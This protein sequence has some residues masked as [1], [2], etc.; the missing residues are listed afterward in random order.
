MLGQGLT[1]FFAMSGMLI[2]L[3]FVRD[4][5][6]GRRRL[7]VG[8]YAIRR[9]RRVF[10]VY[11][12]IFVVANFALHAVYVENAVAVH[13]PRSDAGTGELTG[14]VP[15]LLNL[16]LLQSFSPQWLQTGINPSWSLTT[17][18]TFYALLPLLMIPLVGRVR[19]RFLA[20]LAPA[21]VLWVGGLCGRAWA[22][23]LF[24]GMVGVS[25]LEA[26]YGPHPVAVLSRSLLGLGDMFA[27]GI[28]IAVL[29]V[30]TER[31]E[32]PQ[33]TARRARVACALLLVAGTA[34]AIFFHHRE[35]WLLGAFTTLVA[36]AL[37][38]RITD[39]EA[40]GDSSRFV[41]MIGWRPLD[42]VGRVSLSVYLVHFPVIVLL[43]RAR[44]FTHDSVLSAVGSTL[45]TAAI[46]LAVAAVTYA[47]I[48][49]PA[50]TGEWP[51]W[52]SAGRQSRP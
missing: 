11:I 44:L 31:G 6:A 10:P 47:W 23:Y 18:L 50:L 49:R 36:G 13:T 41:R 35:P 5:A 25:P 26:E 27:V 20:A 33:W 37:V 14:W 4:I 52:R 7:R 21:A 19:R 34:G 24:H 48:E 16:T 12:A 51:R 38:L 46:S 29:F 40:R 43:T 15:V 32:L 3:P 1:V 22:T 28:V 9:L 2:S 42:Y 17:E 45:L 39:P 8:R 30:W